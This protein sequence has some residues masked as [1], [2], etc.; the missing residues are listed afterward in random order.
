[1]I[2]TATSDNGAEAIG[3]VSGC[4]GHQGRGHAPRTSMM[5]RRSSGDAGRIAA[6]FGE[7]A[8]LVNNAGITRDNLLARMSDEEWDDVL[9]T[10]LKSVFRLVGRCCAA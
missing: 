4:G 5:P 1:M 10:N 6:Q 7:I 3:G 2:G 8:I 9:A